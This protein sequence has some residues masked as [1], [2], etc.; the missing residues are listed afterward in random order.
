MSLYELL[1]EM[2]A[3]GEAVQ[4]VKQAEDRANTAFII[5]REMSPSAS[6]FISLLEAATRAYEETRHDYIGG[7]V[8]EQAHG[9]KEYILKWYSYALVG[10]S[11]DG[12][13][14]MQLWG[15]RPPSRQRDPINI[16]NPT[17]DLVIENET[18]VLR[19][20]TDR[21]RIIGQ[22]LVVASSELPAAIANI[23]AIGDGRE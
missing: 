21:S 22:D 10:R 9:D 12:S 13:R 3:P 2:K 16:D 14:R 19:D 23:R 6:K 17:G 8:R 18:I 5:E 1:E 7:S 4:D 11:A 15:S 20:R